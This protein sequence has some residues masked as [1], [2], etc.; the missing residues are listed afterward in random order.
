MSNIKVI[1]TVSDDEFDHSS[2]NEQ[3]EEETQAA[4]QEEDAELSP[5]EVY[6][7]AKE[8]THFNANDA[9]EYFTLVADFD[10]DDESLN[11][12]KAKSVAHAAII[13]S[14]K[15]ED[16][17]QLSSMFLR[18]HTYFKQ[19]KLSLNKL[20]KT[21]Q[22]I[23]LNMAADDD[24]Q[25]QFLLKVAH[26]MDQTRGLS[27][28]LDMTLKLAELHLK[29]GRYTEA[30]V[31]IA[32]S[33]RLIPLPPDKDDTF[34]CQSSLN[35]L[36]MKLDTLTYRQKF[37]EADSAYRQLTQIATTL[38]FTLDK[39]ISF[40]SSPNWATFVYAHGI[41]YLQN[42]D[43]QTATRLLYESFKQYETVKD[44]KVTNPI[45][46][47]WL[48]SIL[49]KDSIIPYQSSEYR[50][51]LGH[52]VISIMK[53]LCDSYIYQHIPDIKSLKTG[54]DSIFYT[55]L[56]PIYGD[57][58]KLIIEN[59]VEQAIIKTCASYSRVSFD[60]L[61]KTIQFDKK[62]I[63]RI[64]ATLISNRKLSGL[65]DDQ[66]GSLIMV[67]QNTITS[68]YMDTILSILPGV[69]LLCKLK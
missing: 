44:T 25:T 37:S 22:S 24:K 57:F 56:R 30:E 49:A 55:K 17:D 7:L 23:L 8:N 10:D 42:K 40:L 26:E 35:F 52:P 14:N 27:I 46:Y 53:N 19:G 6:A 33:E 34:L 31:L 51:Y 29:Y 54:Y 21:A 66:N 69:E 36:I 63:E 2:E 60:F 18:A 47:I 67:R 12:L 38:G 65:I 43:Y 61:S 1:S 50:N 39:K 28:H 41:Q 58:F 62:D 48:A 4:G 9:L 15:K 20:K 13:L 16:I 45:P 64:S 68:P 11:H 3:E 32:D 59:C 5:A